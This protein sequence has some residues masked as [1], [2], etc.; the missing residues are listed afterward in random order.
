MV[1]QKCLRFG[2]TNNLHGVK[3]V[4]RLCRPNINP[5]VI[6]CTHKKL[7]T[8]TITNNSSISGVFTARP[9]RFT[10]QSNSTILSVN[11]T[12]KSTS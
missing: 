5:P 10:H 7:S 3:A 2:V 6:A 12:F 1:L 9:T 11:K 4:P 8:C